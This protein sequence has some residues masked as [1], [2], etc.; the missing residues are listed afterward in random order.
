MMRL[1]LFV[2]A[3]ALW[4]G[5]VACGGGGGSTGITSS[6]TSPAAVTPNPTVTYLSGGTASGTMAVFALGIAGTPGLN[7]T[8]FGFGGFSVPAAQST[9]SPLVLTLGQTT[10]VQVAAGQTGFSTFVIVPGTS[11]FAVGVSDGKCVSHSV[12]ATSTSYLV[13]LSAA[14]SDPLPCGVVLIS[15]FLSAD[16]STLLATPT[17][18]QVAH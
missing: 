2:A 7:L 10:T 12:S 5:A 9:A 4:T 13:I 18:V 1:R 8:G 15:D 14:S 11:A 3:L 6:A 16:G 17:F